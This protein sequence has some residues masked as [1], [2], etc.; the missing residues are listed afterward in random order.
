MGVARHHEIRYIF[1]MKAIV[2]KGFLESIPTEIRT[3]LHLK[4]GMV[5]DFDE[6][7]PYLKATTVAEKDE[8]TITDEEFQKWL[9]G[10]IGIAKGMPSTD[11]MMRETRGED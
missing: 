7:T 11:E 5:V 8:G 6:T 3:R 4:T 9:T 2:T 1:T 10:S